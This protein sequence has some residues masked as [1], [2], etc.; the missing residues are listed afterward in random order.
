MPMPSPRWALLRSQSSDHSA[1]A[2]GAKR[3]PVQQRPLSPANRTTSLRKNCTFAVKGSQSA[4]TWSSMQEN[5]HQNCLKTNA[6]KGAKPTCGAGIFP[7]SRWVT[8]GVLCPGAIAEKLQRGFGNLSRMSATSCHF[9][10]SL[11]PK[12]PGATSCSQTFQP[13]MGNWQLPIN[14]GCLLGK[15]LLQAISLHCHWLLSQGFSNK[16]LSHKL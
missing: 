8:P 4:A 10:W 13:P 3:L 16:R 2:M 7:H 9:H 15:T 1:K 6:Q 14:E 12:G 5:F 11:E